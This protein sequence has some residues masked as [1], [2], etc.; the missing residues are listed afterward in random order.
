MY[1]SIIFLCR[2]THAR[3]PTRVGLGWVGLGR[4]RL[5]RVGSGQVGSGRVGS[6]RVMLFLPCVI[7]GLIV[8][9]VCVYSDMQAVKHIVLQM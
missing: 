3:K 9:E 7:I 5:G 6:G 4:V 2:K 8:H 1:A